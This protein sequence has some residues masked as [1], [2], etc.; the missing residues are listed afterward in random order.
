[1]GI[2]TDT[3]GGHVRCRVPERLRY[4]REGGGDRERQ[5]PE[6]GRGSVEGERKEGGSHL[7]HSLLQGPPEEDEDH[8]RDHEGKGRAQ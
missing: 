5:R 1:M 3:N 8:P 4:R 6:V 2:Q 7:T